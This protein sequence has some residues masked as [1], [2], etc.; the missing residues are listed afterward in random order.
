MA[1]KVLIY[2]VII[3][4]IVFLYP[5]KSMAE[6][7][8]KVTVKDLIVKHSI[9]MGMDPAMALSIAKAESN[10]SQDRKSKYGAIGVFQLMPTTAQKMGYNPYHIN[11]NIKGGIQYYK[12]M[13]KMFGTK[14]L[15]L[16]AYNAG[17]GNVKKYKGLPP[18]SETRKFVSSIMNSYNNFKVNPDPAILRYQDSIKGI[19]DIQKEEEIDFRAQH[20]AILKSYLSNQGI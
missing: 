18:F 15:A 11:D 7:V 16:A 5:V 14:E 12:L 20:E 10:F 13:Y 3:V 2:I 6:T 8:S 9:E 1:R 4:F 17:P 19:A